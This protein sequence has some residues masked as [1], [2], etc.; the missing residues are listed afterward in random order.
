[1]LSPGRCG[2][3]CEAR[4]T[5]RVPL[6]MAETDE[7]LRTLGDRQ[8]IAAQTFEHVSQIGRASSEFRV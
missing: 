8:P 4:I 2:R 6:A 1:M 7:Q 5:E 3:V